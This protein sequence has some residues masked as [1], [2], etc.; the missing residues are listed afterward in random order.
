VKFWV[1]ANQGV[2]DKVTHFLRD[3]LQN[4]KEAS[5]EHERAVQK[6]LLLKIVT[7]NQHR[8]DFYWTWLRDNLRLCLVRLEEMIQCSGKLLQL[9]CY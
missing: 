8:L 9:F 6:S 4:L 7:F 3:V 1:A 2:K 5:V